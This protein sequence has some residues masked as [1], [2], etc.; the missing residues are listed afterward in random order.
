MI[1]LAPNCLFLGSKKI[2]SSLNFKVN[3]ATSCAFSANPHNE[4]HKY[5]FDQ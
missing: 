3:P 5:V 2:G 4:G 1:S